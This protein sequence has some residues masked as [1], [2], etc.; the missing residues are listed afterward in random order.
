MFSQMLFFVGPATCMAFGDPHY[1]TFDGQLHHFQGVCNYILAQDCTNGDFSVLVENDDRG[2]QGVSWTQ[3]ATF[4][5]GNVSIDFIQGTTIRA[6]GRPVNLPYVIAPYVHVTQED[7]HVVLR[8][9][10]GV[11]VTWDG[12]SILS[13]NIPYKYAN[14]MCGLCGNYNGN[15]FDE[16]RLRDGRI[17]KDVNEFGNSWQVRRPGDKCEPKRGGPEPCQQRPKSHRDLARST[18]SLPLVFLCARVCVRERVYTRVCTC[19]VYVYE[20][21]RVFSVC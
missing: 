15:Q 20:S 11:T 17:T 12:N 10:V 19:T 8:S 21:V 2:Y 1:N 14:S 18:V 4:N 5:R 9:D 7:R 13:V 6:N 3:E 16:F